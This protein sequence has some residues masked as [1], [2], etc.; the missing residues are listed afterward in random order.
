MDNRFL[1]DMPPRMITFSNSTRLV[2]ILNHGTESHAKI[3]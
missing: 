1:Y 3:C 2:C